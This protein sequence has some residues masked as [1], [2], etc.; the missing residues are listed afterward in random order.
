MDRSLVERSL[1][2]CRRPGFWRWTILPGV[3]GLLLLLVFLARPTQARQDQDALEQIRKQ[4]QEAGSYSFKADL[5]QLTI[6]LATARNVGRS[7]RRS[8]MRVEGETNLREATLDMQI[9]S[10]GDSILDNVSGME[11][12]VA[13]GRTLAR[14]TGGDWQEINNFSDALAPGGDFL[15]FLAGASDIQVTGEVFP[16]DRRLQ[17]YTYFV[18]GPA[19]AAQLRQY[20]SA[21]LKRQGA[22]LPGAQLK[23]PE[24]YSR[25][26]GE[27]ELWIGED[28][29]PVRQIVRLRFP[30]QK[31]QRSRNPRK[32]FPAYRRRL[33]ER[34]SNG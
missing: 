27:G 9:W 6:R 21:D 14:Q 2:R 13:E 10:Q 15:T 17:R 34:N 30:A 28:G 7:S 11:I 20:M 16:G 1:R 3:A 33:A 19:F 12:R 4:V 31:G 26:R 32:L 24:M 18:D 25:L 8:E 23:A 5:V 29:L 22:L